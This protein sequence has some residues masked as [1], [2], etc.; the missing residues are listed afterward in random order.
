MGLIRES[1]ATIPTLFEDFY[2]ITYVGQFFLV[3]LLWL[4]FGNMVRYLNLL[5]ICQ[6]LCTEV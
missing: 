1:F 4:F 3:A 5:Y 6:C 2:I